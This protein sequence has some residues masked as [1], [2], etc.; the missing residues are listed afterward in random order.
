MDAASE[1]V[2]T[3]PE[4]RRRSGK[5]VTALRAN[6]I[7]SRPEWLDP[8]FADPDQVIGMVHKGAP[9]QLISAAHGGALAM[10]QQMPW[11]R[12][13]WAETGKPLVEGADEVLHNPRFVEASKKA[14]QAEIVRPEA[15][16]VNLQGPME[17]AVPHVDLPTFRGIERHANLA[18][19]RVLMGTSGLFHAW[20]VPVAAAICWF[21]RGSD[22][23]FEYWPHGPHR[24]VNIVRMPQWNT[25]LVADNDYMFHRIG[26]IGPAARHIAPDYLSARS[27]LQI[28][29]DGSW[30]V[31]D[32]ARIKLRYFANEIR[33]SVL[34]KGY[35]FQT[36]DIAA[37]FDDHEDDLDA[38]MVF[39]IF[40]E[41][42]RAREIKFPVP[43]DPLRDREWLGLLGK[44]YPMVTLPGF[45]HFRRYY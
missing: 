16:L 27:V 33:I 12:A 8:A 36:K 43:N 28:E 30:R 15:V 13:F 14:F 34:W 22:G 23:A 42:L 7:I 3:D 11:F 45:E 6:E 2:R 18:S 41:D 17:G 10:T 37:Q 40:A 25:A 39:S 5:K 31:E 32:D 44:I 26:D 19:I 29:P 24:P 20:S 35:A 4:A 9:Y 21:Y 38:S 1:Q